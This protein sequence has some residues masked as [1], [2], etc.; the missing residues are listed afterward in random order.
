MFLMRTVYSSRM[1]ARTEA[2]PILIVS[3][4]AP[5][6]ESVSLPSPHTEFGSTGAPPPP[7]PLADAEVDAPEVADVEPAVV[8]ATVVLAAAVLLAAAL[9]AAAVLPA[10]V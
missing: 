1:P 6:S 4:V 5:W 2:K 8:L 9:V 3:A 10:A 7:P